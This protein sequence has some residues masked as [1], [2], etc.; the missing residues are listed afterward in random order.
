LLDYLGAELS[1]ISTFIFVFSILVPQVR[2]TYEAHQVEPSCLVRLYDL[3]K[4]ALVSQRVPFGT[5]SPT[6][7]HPIGTAPTP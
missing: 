5:N 1:I 6:A 4:V 7:I 3:W 2:G